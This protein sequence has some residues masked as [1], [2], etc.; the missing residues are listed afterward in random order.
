MLVLFFQEFCFQNKVYVITSIVRA[1]VGVQGGRQGYILASD[2]YKK[3]KEVFQDERAYF[4]CQML[5]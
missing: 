4:V 5:L 3:I 2:S 1:G